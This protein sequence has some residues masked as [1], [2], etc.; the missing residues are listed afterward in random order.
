MAF[1]DMYRS[2]YILG[3]QHADNGSWTRPAWWL[4]LTKPVLWLPLI[5]DRPRYICGYRE[6]FRDALL[7]Q[8][9]HRTFSF[10]DN[11]KR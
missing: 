8:G 2:G 5:A 3:I 6:G 7:A 1:L 11:R 9:L 10:S 4:L